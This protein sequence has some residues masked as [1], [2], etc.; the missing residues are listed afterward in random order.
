MR[1]RRPFTV[2]APTRKVSLRR[3]LFLLAVVGVLPLAAL[4]GIGLFAQI[5]QQR[6]QAERV[7]LDVARALATAVDSELRRAQSVLEALAAVLQLENGDIEGFN[8][9]AQ[10]VVRIGGQ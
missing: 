10:N 9:I 2:I 6:A 1:R 4:A 7:G 8:A 5:Q 3:R